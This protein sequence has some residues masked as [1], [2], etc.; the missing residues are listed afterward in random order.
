METLQILCSC[1]HKSEIVLHEIVH[2]DK[3]LPRCRCTVCGKLG[4][5][6]MI[7][8]RDPRPGRAI[9]AQDAEES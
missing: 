5:K 2:R 4:A 3:L 9:N 6:D 1:G 7:L 8:Q